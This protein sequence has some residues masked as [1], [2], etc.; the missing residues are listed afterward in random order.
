MFPLGV[1]VTIGGIYTL[2]LRGTSD[3][4]RSIEGF[5][6]LSSPDEYDTSPLVRDRL[7]SLSKSNIQVPRKTSKNIEV[8]NQVSHE[9]VPISSR[10][11]VTIT[12]EELKL[13]KDTTIELI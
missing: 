12:T 8:G 10:A 4:E 7:R 9:Y 6:E 11:E 2:S 5:S 1:F 3:A 13:G